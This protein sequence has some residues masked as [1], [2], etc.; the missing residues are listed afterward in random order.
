[1]CGTTPLRYSATL[2][3]CETALLLLQRGAAVSAKYLGGDT[4]LHVAMDPL[5]LGWPT[6]PFRAT[7]DLL[8]RWEA[9]EAAVNNKSLTPLHLADKFISTLSHASHTFHGQTT[10]S[11]MAYLQT[12]RKLLVRAPADRAWR[13]RCLLVMLRSRNDRERASL[14]PTRCCSEGKKQE[15]EEKGDRAMNEEEVGDGAGSAD[16]ETG[17]AEGKQ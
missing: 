13:R 11:S 10:A 9:S 17:V 3:D 1:M 15:Q 5:S 4:A 2:W 6:R 12:A 14:L 8:L 16:D 7:I